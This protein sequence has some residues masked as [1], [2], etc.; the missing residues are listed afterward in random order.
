MAIAMI[1]PR[2][3]MLIA[4]ETDN[5]SDPY[6]EFLAARLATPVWRLFGED[7][8]DAAPV[9]DQPTGGA[10]TFLLHAGGHGPAPQDTPAILDFLDRYLAPKRN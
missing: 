6:G 7:G 4:G 10:L 2:P 9:L 1:A 3:L 8:V 5:W